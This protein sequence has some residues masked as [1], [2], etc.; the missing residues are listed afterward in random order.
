LLSPR[1]EHKQPCAQHT[2]EVEK[3]REREQHL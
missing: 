2:I 1:L 3:E